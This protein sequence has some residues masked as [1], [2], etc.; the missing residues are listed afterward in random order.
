MDK[1]LP[2]IS[3]PELNRPW[4]RKLIGIVVT[5][6]VLVV[7]GI[8]GVLRLSHTAPVSTANGQWKPVVQTFDGVEMVLVPPGC[9]MMGSTQAQ[10]G[11]LN[12]QIDARD[13]G[14]PFAKTYFSGHDHIDNEGPQ[15]RVCFDKPFWLD[16]YEVTNRQ[17][18]QFNGLA[19]QH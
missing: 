1:P 18:A 16:R 12:K 2:S 3:K 13:N 10:I 8:V 6:V 14:N 5:F 9:F 19:A 15:S 7:I 4:N 11:D 17:F